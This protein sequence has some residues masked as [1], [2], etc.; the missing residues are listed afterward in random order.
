MS[1]TPESGATRSLPVVEQAGEDPQ[2]RSDSSADGSS[3]SGSSAAGQPLPT[4]SADDKAPRFWSSR[5]VPAA[6]LAV[7]GLGVAGLFLYDVV[8]VRAGHRAMSWRRGLARR[9]GEWSLDDTAVLV[10][11][12]VAALVG[13]WLLVLAVTPGR[14]ALLPMRRTDGDVRAGLHRA[15]AATLLRDRAMDVSGVQS[16]RVRLT[17]A[18]AD[19]RAVAHFRE[20]DDVRG[21]LDAALSDGI[22]DLGLARTPG[23]AVRVARPGRK[24]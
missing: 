9:L 19:V 14:R 5:R 11:A 8:A 2:S 23:L 7:V 17:R 21:D 16:A 6:L 24:G 13:L 12:G 1:E 15:A 18:K 4:L 22:R 10:G 3:S 20:L